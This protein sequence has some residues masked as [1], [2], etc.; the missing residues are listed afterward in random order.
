M[1]GPSTSPD[2]DQVTLSSLPTDGTNAI[3][4][5]GVSIQNFATNFAGQS[6]TVQPWR[7]PPAVLNFQGHVVRRAGGIEA[8]GESTSRTRATR[9]FATWF[10]HDESGKR[11][12]CR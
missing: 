11:G 7:G 4:R 12:T 9:I 3:N 1:A 10:T 2:V 6:A 5:N 8:A